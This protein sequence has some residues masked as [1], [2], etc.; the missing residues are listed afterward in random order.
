MQ[1]SLMSYLTG[2]APSSSSKSGAKIGKWHNLHID[3]CA[4]CADNAVLDASHLSVPASMS[5]YAFGT[6]ATS[7]S[8][9]AV[10]NSTEVPPRH[11]INTAYMTS[12]NHL[13]CYICLSDAMLRA[14]DDGGSPWECL[15]CASSVTW[16]ERAE[17]DVPS[18]V[19]SDA[20]LDEYEFSDSLG[21]SVGSI[22]TLDYTNSSESHSQ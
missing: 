1:S 21:D 20:S 12:C 2:F 7:A 3:E 22:Q 16:C 6:P 18:V 10:P 14:R 13:Y 19:D 5:S 8:T 4:I 17:A 9:M 11:P 15:R